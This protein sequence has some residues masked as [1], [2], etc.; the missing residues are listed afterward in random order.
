MEISNR[1]SRDFVAGFQ[2]GGIYSPPIVVNG[3]VYFGSAD[4]FLYALE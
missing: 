1:R 4:G 3:V 2:I